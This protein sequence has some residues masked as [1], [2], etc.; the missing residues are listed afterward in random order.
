MTLGD[1][2]AS[3]SPKILHEAIV[4]AIALKK[5]ST[6]TELALKNSRRKKQKRV[7]A[8]HNEVL[9]TKEVVQHLQLEAEERKG[10]DGKKVRGH[11]QKL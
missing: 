2:V 1:V 3:L 6:E 11:Q 8:T 9:T 5:S 4:N 10:K 7:H